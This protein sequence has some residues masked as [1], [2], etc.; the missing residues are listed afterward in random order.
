MRWTIPT[1]VDTLHRNGLPLDKAGDIVAATYGLTGGDEDF[2]LR[3][4]HFPAVRSEGPYAIWSTV[5]GDHPSDAPTHA[6]ADARSIVAALRDPDMQLDDVVD[7][8]SPP[9]LLVIEAVGRAV[10]FIQAGGLV[11]PTQVDTNSDLLA[12]AQQQGRRITDQAAI[13]GPLFDTMFR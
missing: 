13:V 6:G 11:A 9:N 3:C 12:R 10:T 8:S 2:D 1:L 5:R 4:T 7:I